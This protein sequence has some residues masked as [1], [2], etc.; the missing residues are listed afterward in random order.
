M[1]SLSR[2]GALKQ[3][4]DTL[5]HQINKDAI[6][7]VRWTGSGILTSNGYIRFYSGGET[8]ITG[9]GFLMEER[10]KVLDFQAEN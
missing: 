9:T 8:I 4:T 5:K 6:Q 2:P 7:E 3:V 1:C 10:L